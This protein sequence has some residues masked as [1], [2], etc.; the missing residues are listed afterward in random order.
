MYMAREA[1]GEAV[2]VEAIRAHFPALQRQHGGQPVAYFDGPGG[3]QVPASVPAAITDY[4]LHHNA[5]AHWAFPTS[6]E[7][8]AI[9]LAA[10]EA[11][12]EFLNCAPRE[13]VFGANMTTLAFHLA[14]AI[15][16]GLQTDDE[17]VVT[18]LDHHANRAPWQAIA[19]E[20]GLVLRS[21]QLDT[22][23]GQLDW[24]DFA[25]QVTPR[26]RLVAVGAA[27]NALGTVNDIKRAVALAKAV[28]AL[29]FVD[30]VAY[31]PHALVDV[32][33]WDCDFLACSAYK[34]YGPHVGVL[35][36]KHALLEALDVPKLE[37]APDTAPDR[38]ETGTGNFEGIAGAA[39]AVDFLASL[40]GGA[41][42]RERL[43]N[44]FAGLHANATALFAEL[45]EGLAGIPGLRLFGPSPHAA[46]IPTLS[47]TLEGVPAERLSR[48]LANAGLFASSGNFYAAT[49][50]ERYGQDAEG[51]LRIG[52]SCYS[53]HTEVARLVQAVRSLSIAVSGNPT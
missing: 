22:A 52:L 25:R 41:T 9:V 3:T 27:S 4:L 35:Y 17:I 11:F 24:D 6:V 37:P 26:T 16:R 7:T 10:R 14:R 51:F 2:K 46:R 32:Q 8:D 49:V 38:L 53:T 15:G 42:R 5:N 36:G 48:E 20:R 31:A 34:F 44:A 19:K 40:A 33:H 39:A 29:T 1:M 43:E 13:I 45:W 47:L 30:A 23:T 21:V 12:A 50:A 28:G 18:D